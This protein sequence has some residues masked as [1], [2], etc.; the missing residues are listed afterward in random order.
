MSNIIDKL[1]GKKPT[2]AKSAKERLQLVLVTDRVSMSPD[3]MD[4]MQKEILA[5]IRKYC[6]VRDDE[7]DFKFEQRD[8]ENYLV[9][10]IPL[11]AKDEDDYAGSLQVR[12]NIVR[13]RLSI[14]PEED[15]EATLPMSSAELRGL[16]KS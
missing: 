10:D 9:A 2:S 13:D 4:S 14:D 11:V 15:D 7:V 5:V 8:R 6:R 12:T 3:E 1:M 16:D